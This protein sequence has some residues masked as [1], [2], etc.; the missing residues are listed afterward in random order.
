MEIKPSFIRDTGISSR[1]QRAVTEER[2]PSK[3]GTSG[4]ASAGDQV[5]LTAA[6][7]SLLEASRSASPSVDGARVAAL[8]EAI[9][10]GSYQVDASRIAEKLLALDG[11]F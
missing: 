2:S 10:S 3:S 11:E 7:Q 1:S 4:Q 5:T 9:E 8:R 6:A